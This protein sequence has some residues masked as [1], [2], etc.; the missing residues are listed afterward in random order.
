[1]AFKLAVQTSKM[2]C[3]CTAHEMVAGIA[4][5]ESDNLEMLYC[6]YDYQAAKNAIAVANPPIGYIFK[7]DA[8]TAASVTMR[9]PDAEIKVTTDR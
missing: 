2:Q 3:V 4:K 1:M 8:G 7:G 5:D 6:G 9:A